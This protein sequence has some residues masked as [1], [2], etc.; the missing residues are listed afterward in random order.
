MLIEEV[1]GSEE[2]EEENDKNNRKSEVEKSRN[3]VVEN[4]DITGTNRI[5]VLEDDD[6]KSPTLNASASVPDVFGNSSL[7]SEPKPLPSATVS[8][9]P[10]PRAI[11]ELKDD[12]NEL[13]RKG[14]Y[15]DAIE[16]YS[17]AIQLLT[18]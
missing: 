10:L 12:G 11:Q 16:K 4:G 17:A 6:K 7:S 1:E 15:A 3:M 8:T 2:D 13:F 5:E 9:E 18:S 14:Q